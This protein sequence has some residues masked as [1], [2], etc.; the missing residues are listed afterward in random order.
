M[1]IDRATRGVSSAIK[2]HK[3]AASARAFLYAR[4]PACPLKITQLLTD[5]GQ[6]FTDQLFGA[7][8]RP[9]PGDHEFDP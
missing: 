9:P 7:K 1:A 2:P 8:D 3:T 4:H 5:H 6:E